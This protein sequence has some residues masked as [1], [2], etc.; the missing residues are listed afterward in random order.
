[1]LID[2]RTEILKLGGQFTLSTPLINQLSWHH[3][4]LSEKNRLKFYLFYSGEISNLYQY[5]LKAVLQSVYASCNMT[6]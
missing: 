2:H 6:S 5:H 1:M 3:R 4:L